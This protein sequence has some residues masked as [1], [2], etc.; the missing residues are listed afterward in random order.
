MNHVTPKQLAQLRAIFDRGLVAGL[1]DDADQGRTCIEGAIS[2]VFEG[3]LGDKPRCVHEVDRR[4]AI[5]IND[6]RW[7]SPEAR[8]QALF[9]IALAQID[10][11]GKDRVKWV[12][13]VVVGTIQRVLPIALEACNMQREAEA[14][15][16]AT[17]L[18]S[19]KAAATAAYATADAATAAAA[20]A[21]AAAY[22]YDA[23]LR[24]AVAVALDAYAAEKEEA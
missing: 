21:Y 19:A 18:E 15:R 13:R 14:C 17:D 22:A 5:K 9:P 11:A 24:E 7:S 6:A 4:W 8:A 23:V 3:H 12:E 10:T 16:Q 1:K 2:L 20:A